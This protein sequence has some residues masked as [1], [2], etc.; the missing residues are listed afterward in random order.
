MAASAYR[1]EAL[2]LLEISEDPEKSMKLDLG[3]KLAQLFP[4]DDSGM[5]ADAVVVFAS[6]KIWGHQVDHVYE[7][8]LATGNKL[9]QAVKDVVEK[10]V[11]GILEKQ[12]EKK[13]RRRKIR[14]HE[15]EN[16]KIVYKFEQKPLKAAKELSSVLEPIKKTEIKTPI[17]KLKDFFEKQRQGSRSSKLVMPKKF[18][19]SNDNE[20]V[21]IYSDK[22]P[23][24][25]M[26]LNGTE[27]IGT[28]KDF[29]SFS[30]VLESITGELLF[31]HNFNRYL[32]KNLRVD[33]QGNREDSPVMESANDMDIDFELTPPVDNFLSSTFQDSGLLSQDLLASPEIS[34]II[35]PDSFG[36]EN[37]SQNFNSTTLESKNSTET[38]DNSANLTLN[39]TDPE[40]TTNNLESSDLSLRQLNESSENQLPDLDA[41]PPDVPENLQFQL[42]LNT[43][44]T[45]KEID[46]VSMRSR[47]SVSLLNIRDLANES[48]Q[49]LNLHDTVDLKKLNEEIRKS[50]KSDEIELN[51]LG[52]PLKKLTKMTNFT[53][54]PELAALLQKKKKEKK[55]DPKIL[56]MNPNG[57]TGLTGKKSTK[58]VADEDGDFTPAI[59]VRMDDCFFGF[60]KEQITKGPRDYDTEEDVDYIIDTTEP[61]PPLPAVF[62]NFAS[63]EVLEK[64]DEKAKKRQSTDSGIESS[65]ELQNAPK[66]QKK[67][68]PEKKEPVYSEEPDLIEN[69]D[70]ITRRRDEQTAAMQEI[71]RE[72]ARFFAKINPFLKPADNR[73]NVTYCK[74]LLE[75]ADKRDGNT[76]LAEILP[77]G[78]TAY[79]FLCT[80]MMVNQG[81]FKITHAEDGDTIK[82]PEDIKIEL[83]S[84]QLNIEQLQKSFGTVEETSAKKSKSANRVEIPEPQPNTLE[85]TPKKLKPT[86]KRKIMKTS[87]PIPEK[88]RRISENTSPYQRVQLNPKALNVSENLSDIE[89][90]SEPFVTQE[91]GYLTENTPQKSSPERSSVYSSGYGSICSSSMYSMPSCSS[92]VLATTIINRHGGLY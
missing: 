22:N 19:L 33:F 75:E 41:V 52:I 55:E 34:S 12:A 73:N 48:L 88:M 42:P 5:I 65:S 61:P 66:K 35:N 44:L 87:T 71:T 72:V 8:G 84:K 7:Y 86:Q 89:E 16:D 15:L 14:I 6:A 90:D 80:L 13:E 17:E 39:S 53:L 92:N 78:E 43:D 81:N 2:K 20:V 47:A 27:P 29:P 28:R 85:I 10:A 4:N 57:S 11:D 62:D 58:L 83:V 67:E 46:A 77:Q 74:N 32:S 54:P 64:F 23:E 36:L 49:N 31:D 69:D 30:Y 1:D 26:D 51:V 38:P 9:L 59:V 40:T 50:I 45:P 82:N 56:D 18:A 70:E 79:G 25:I 76:S 37:S 24:Y 68:K 63:P 21:S 60:T 3:G 91:S